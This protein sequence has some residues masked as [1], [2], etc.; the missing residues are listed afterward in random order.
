MAKIRLNLDSDCSDFYDFLKNKGRLLKKIRSNDKCVWRNTNKTKIKLFKILP[1][2][3]FQKIWPPYL[4][5]ISWGPNPNRYKSCVKNESQILQI[6]SEKKIIVKIDKNC[7]K[8]K[9][10]KTIS[11]G[12]I[13][14][15]IQIQSEE[16]YIDNG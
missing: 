4:K 8:N 13:L 15:S 1:P 2:F 16:F 9:T 11:C 14:G 6:K 3:C 12:A 10:R 5:P 7:F